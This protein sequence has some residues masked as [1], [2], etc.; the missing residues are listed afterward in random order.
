MGRFLILRSLEG[1]EVEGGYREGVY[2]F[3]S[4]AAL[5]IAVI[6]I[7]G[8]RMIQASTWT[9]GVLGFWV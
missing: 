9:G 7:Y 2:S 6:E 1:C 3:F 8:D 5:G 4:N